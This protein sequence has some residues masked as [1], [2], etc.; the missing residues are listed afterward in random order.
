METTKLSSK[1]QVILPR[2]V[3]DAHNWPPGTEFAV[4]TAANGVLLRPLR[5]FKPTTLKEVLGSTGYRGKAK[6]LADMEKAVAR[7]VKERNARGR[8]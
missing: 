5:S 7:G 8:Y 2:S 1:G 6:S 4:E 3:R